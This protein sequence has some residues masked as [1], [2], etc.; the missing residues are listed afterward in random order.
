MIYFI[1]KIFMFVADKDNVFREKM[2]KKGLLF[3]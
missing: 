3:I 2:Q 1:I